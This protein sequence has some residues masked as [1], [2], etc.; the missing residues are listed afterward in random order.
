MICCMAF[1]CGLLVQ[2]FVDSRAL[3][4]YIKPMEPFPTIRLTRQEVERAALDLG[5]KFRTIQQWR[6]RGVPVRW[7]LELIKHFGAV[8]LIDDVASQALPPVRQRTL[9]DICR[10]RF[11]TPSGI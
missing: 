2:R 6:S 4:Y 1:I 11:L 8:I 10:E 5:A 9:A 7:Q 3:F